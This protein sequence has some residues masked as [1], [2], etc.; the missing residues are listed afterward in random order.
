M[1]VWLSMLLGIFI[2]RFMI[3]DEIGKKRR[4]LMFLSVSFVL[5][6]F[7]VGS[8]SPH[9]SGSGDL[10]TYYR[11]YGDAL[12]NPVSYLVEN[13]SMERGY[14][15]FNKIIAWIV[16]WN[17]FIVY[18]E[19]AFCTAIMFW[20]IYRNAES[21][22]LGVIVYI[23]MGPWQF[24]LTG[25]RQSFAICICFIA[26]ELVKKKHFIYDGIAVGLIA[27]A[28]AL[29]VTAWVFLSVFLLRVIDVTKRVVIYASVLTVFLFVT[30]DNFLVF[31]NDLLGREYT[32]EYYGNVFAGL[33]PIVAYIGTFVLC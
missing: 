31:G 8:R 30:F 12:T 18:F 32:D 22:F 29:H 25:F 28:A 20:Y 1:W 4:D 19:V 24:F 10:F 9:L 26:F 11:C 33:I 3:P 14:L 23:C 5:I 27:L 6:V 15:V 17:Y 7:V 16:P 21:V 13:Y 2:I